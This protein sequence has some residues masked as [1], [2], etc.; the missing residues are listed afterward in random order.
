MEVLER[1]KDKAETVD[2]ISK[3]KLVTGRLRINSRGANGHAV[4]KV[5]AKG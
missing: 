5:E 3:P 2:R 1:I 4:A